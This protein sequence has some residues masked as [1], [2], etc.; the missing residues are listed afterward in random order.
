VVAGAAAARRYYRLPKR[1]VN[2]VLLGLGLVLFLALVGYGAALRGL[3]HHLIVAERLPAHADA[4][5]VMGGGDK[6]G[7]R[8]AQ[9]AALYVRG[10]A[11]LVLTTGGPVTGEAAPATYAEWSVQRLE[12]RGV[13]RT[14]V[15]PTNE[16]DSTVGDARGVR[17]L[18]QAR[19][20]HDLV[21][22]TDSWHSHRTEVAFRSVFQDS[23]IRVYSSPARSPGFDPDAWWTDEDA[24][25]AV[26]TEYIKLAAFYAGVRD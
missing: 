6:S 20:W 16:G 13:P 18:A 23:A 19:G 17:K 12:R 21:V 1:L 26:A 8:E 9:A 24:A 15:V 11:P 7:T 25:L 5:V 14:A 2:G 10:L 3:G 22:V 4:I